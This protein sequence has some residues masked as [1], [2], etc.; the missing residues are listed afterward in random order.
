MLQSGCKRI[1]LAQHIG[2]VRLE[3][4]VAGVGDSHHASLWV[5]LLK[6]ICLRAGMRGV[7]RSLAFTLRLSRG[8]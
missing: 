8:R 7:L 2:F 1:D 3:D 6:G 5:A 4:K